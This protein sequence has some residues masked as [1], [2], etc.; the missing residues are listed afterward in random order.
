[1]AP[2]RHATGAL[3]QSLDKPD[4]P[5]VPKKQLRK[6]NATLGNAAIQ[7]VQDVDSSS[8]S[9]KQFLITAVVALVLQGLSSAIVDQWKGAELA[10]VSRNYESTWKFLALTIGKVLELGVGWYAGYGSELTSMRD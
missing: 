1:M 10:S 7:N 5:S 9:L 2:K 6:P 3:T 8:E 4:A